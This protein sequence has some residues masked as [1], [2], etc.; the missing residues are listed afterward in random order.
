MNREGE[1]ISYSPI[2]LPRGTQ[3]QLNAKDI[4]TYYEKTFGDVF[5]LYASIGLT[6]RS[7]LSPYASHGLLTFGAVV[8][9]GNGVIAHFPSTPSP[10][11]HIE[12]GG[13]LSTKYSTKG[14]H[15]LHLSTLLLIKIVPNCI[16]LQYLNTHQPHLRL[17]FSLRLPLKERTQLR[18]AYLS[19]HPSG[20]RDFTYFIDEIGFSLIGDFPHS[21]IS[22]YLFVP[23]L[24]GEYINGMYCIC[25]PLPDSLFYWAS[26]PEGNEVLPEDNWERYSIPNLKV[27]TTIGSHWW[28]DEYA[29]VLQHLMEKNYGLDRKGYAQDKGYPELVMGDPHKRRMEELEDSDEGQPSRTVSHLTSPS[30]FSLVNA[31]AKSE[32]LCE[33]GFSIASHMAKRLGLWTNTSA[34]KVSQMKGKSSFVSSESKTDN[35]DEWDWVDSK[36]L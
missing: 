29:S 35:P 24:R 13:Q 31:P 23:P 8:E 10:K 28:H 11:W 30:L 19:Q 1:T 22:A 17:Y 34:N 32:A 27:E 21:P 18:A 7:D 9:C 15:K 25:H 20:A 12:D 26:D 33:E 16:D 2:S 4:A 36:N 3:P 14:V 5:Y 6:I